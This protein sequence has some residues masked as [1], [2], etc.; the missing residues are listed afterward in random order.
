MNIEGDY[1]YADAGAFDE[2]AGFLEYMGECGYDWEE[3]FINWIT[4]A[5]KWKEDHKMPP[6]YWD[7]WNLVKV[8]KFIYINQNVMLLSILTDS[9]LVHQ[10]NKT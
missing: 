5:E 7:P 10:G 3:A 9:Q 8:V 4:V 6:S 2:C 1:R